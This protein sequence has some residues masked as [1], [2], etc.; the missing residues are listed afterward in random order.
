METSKYN[1]MLECG[2]VAE[3]SPSLTQPWV[4][5]PELEGKK[6][7]F[8]VAE[9]LWEAA[10]A[11]AG[12]LGPVLKLS[13][14]SLCLYVFM[15]V[16]QTL[17]DSAL[18]LKTDWVVRAEHHGHRQGLTGATVTGFSGLAQLQNLPSRR[19]GRETRLNP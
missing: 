17:Q 4:L 12:Q 3:H 2:S 14:V 16:L 6:K 18:S 7:R 10:G 15:K 13:Q 11:H 1:A 9:G 5:S 8:R 19:Q